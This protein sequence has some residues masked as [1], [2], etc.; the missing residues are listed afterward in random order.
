M[1]SSISV[2]PDWDAVTS[3]TRLA[4][5]SATARAGSTMY[6]VRY[7]S[8]G[9][10]IGADCGY[11]RF[12]VAHLSGVICADGRVRSPTRLQARGIRVGNSS[13]TLKETMDFLFDHAAQ[14]QVA[15][16]ARGKA[17]QFGAEHTAD[18]VNDCVMFVD[19]DK[20]AQAL[21]CSDFNFVRPRIAHTRVGGMHAGA[22]TFIAQKSNVALHE[23]DQAP[24]PRRMPR[25]PSVFRK[26]I[27][28][29]PR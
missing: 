27:E 17:A 28:A 26:L 16:H 21:G 2:L 5:H 23:I 25:D 6:G 14:W 10:G 8:R 18:R 13:D 22:A 7:G 20:L 3:T 29:L 15:R 4:A 1:S 12:S 11:V 19:C 24:I 9:P